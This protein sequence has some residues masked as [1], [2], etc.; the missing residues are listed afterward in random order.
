MPAIDFR[1]EL[2][3]GTKKCEGMSR[4]KLKHLREKVKILRTVWETDEERIQ[5]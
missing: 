1:T 2:D 3:N 4:E 5:S